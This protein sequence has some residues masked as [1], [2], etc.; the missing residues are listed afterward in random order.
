[1]FNTLT[2][3]VRFHIA[4]WSLSKSI[5]ASSFIENF[6]QISAKSI[7]FQRRKLS[8]NRLFFTNRFSAKLASKIPVKFPRNR[9]FFP[10]IYPWK[11]REIWLYF[12]RPTRS[13]VY[14][15]DPPRCL[16]LYS[17][18]SLS[19]VVPLGAVFN[20]FLSLVASLW[21]ILSL[22]C[23]STLFLLLITSLRAVIW[24]SYFLGWSLHSEL[25][26]SRP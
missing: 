10:R 2:C 7:G 8:R 22:Y 14:K 17:K 18:L 9:L 3:K 6:P 12:P 5:R 1:M 21:P 24:L 11:S 4:V 13:P 25:F 16:L 20:L 26:Y 15:P 19:L 23:H